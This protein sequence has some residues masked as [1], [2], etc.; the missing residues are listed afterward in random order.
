MFS[1]RRDNLLGLKKDVLGAGLIQSAPLLLIPA[2][3]V[4]ISL[5]VEQPHN[6]PEFSLFDVTVQ[7]ATV[8]SCLLQKVSKN[9]FN[10]VSLS[11]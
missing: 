7:S 8:L 4:S 11:V 2:S 3:H 5:S 6:Y 1:M 10:I 9:K